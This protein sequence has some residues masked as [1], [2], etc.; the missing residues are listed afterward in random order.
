MI[1]NTYIMVKKYKWTT[2]NAHLQ[3][4]TGYPGQKFP[5]FSYWAYVQ[6]YCLYDRISVT[7]GQFDVTEHVNDTREALE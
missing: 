6:K 5:V 1:L 3:S 4:Y 2:L 7:L